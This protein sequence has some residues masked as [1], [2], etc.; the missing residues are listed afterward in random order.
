MRVFLVG[1]MGCGKSTLARELSKSLGFRHIDLDDKIEK[2]ARKPIDF[3]FTDRGEERFRNLEARL[4]RETRRLYN[5]VVATGG[6]TA[7]F[8]ENMEWM[9][10]NGI[11]VYIQHTSE[12]LFNR[13][14][15]VRQER[16]LTKGLSEEALK[17]QIETHMA[18]REPHYNK[19]K[20]ILKGETASTEKIISMLKLEPAL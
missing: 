5:I 2:E 16:P 18:L 4:L 20:H 12:A 19:A 1:Y 14:L 10:Q 11:T 15:P 17:E 8:H 6:G 3:V 13:L 7:C 9:N